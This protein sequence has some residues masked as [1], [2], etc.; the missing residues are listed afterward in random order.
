MQ[1]ALE[2]MGCITIDTE[3]SEQ[4]LSIAESI[5]PDLIIIGGADSWSLLGKLQVETAIPI[6][7][8]VADNIGGDVSSAALVLR[9]PLQQE[10]FI[11]AI[12]GAL[13][14]ATDANGH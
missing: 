11:T 12:S 7:V 1:L 6:V 5:A 14:G 13:F 3:D 2:S 9:K 8:C 10:Q 4:I